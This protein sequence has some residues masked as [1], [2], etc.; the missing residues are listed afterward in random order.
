MKPASTVILAISIVLSGC[1][2]YPTYVYQAPVYQAPVPLVVDRERQD[3]CILI[4][5]EIA[6]QQSIAVSSGVMA[7]ALVEGAVRLNVSNVISGLE[8]RAAIAGCPV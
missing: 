7:T 1:V 5:K 4:R 3:E 2:R 6:R 8:T